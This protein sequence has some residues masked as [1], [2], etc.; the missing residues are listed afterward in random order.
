MLTTQERQVLQTV[1][2]LLNV[3]ADDHPLT[4]EERQALDRIRVQTGDGKAVSAADLVLG[5]RAAQRLPGADQVQPQLAAAKVRLR[6][7]DGAETVVS[8]ADL[9]QAPKH[10]KEARVVELLLKSPLPIVPQG[11]MTDPRYTY[12]MVFILV[13]TVLWFGCNNAAREIVKEEAIYLRERSVNLQ[14]GPYLGSKFLLLGSVGA[15]Q[16]LLLLAIIHGVLEGC[17]YAFGYD[18]PAPEYALP[19]WGQ[20]LF[21]VLVTLTGAAL[22]LLLSA[23]VTSPDRA[24]TLLPYVLIP[25]IILGGGFIPIHG[26]PLWWIA[27]IASPVYWGFRAV[28]T[29][30]TELPAGWPFRM[31]Y[32]DSLW[33]PC[34]ALAAQALGLLLVTAWILRGKD[35]WKGRR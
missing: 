6:T 23:C 15:V 33:L 28:R 30:E 5:L 13:I 9:L 29:G 20:Y 26:G 14:I 19:L 31:D 35:V 7:A 1:Q 22:G 21:L 4:A 12:L 17:H 25:Q 18:L 10:L 27:V 34:A 24:A 16:V 8:L 3:L 2:D 32:D 11:E